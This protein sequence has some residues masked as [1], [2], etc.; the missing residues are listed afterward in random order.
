MKVLVLGAS[1]ATG[2]LVVMQLLLR[3]INVRVVVRESAALPREILDNPL[4]EI[5]KGSITEFT[6]TAMR[7]LLQGCDTVV[8]CL[9][10]NITFKGLFGKP[11]NL[12]SHT[13]EKISEIAMEKGD[14]KIK[15]ILMSTTA[16]ANTHTGEKR[17][18][19]ERIILSLL[20]LFLPPHAD[21]VRSAEYLYKEI[22]KDN[23]NVQ[24][25]AVRPD[26]LV[27][28]EIVNPYQVVE[29]PTRSPLFNA[30]TSS[31]INVAHF[32]AEL[33]TDEELWQQWQSKMPVVYN[34]E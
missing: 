12:V 34:K 16:Y 19:G 30:G 31:R 21:N 7:S 11:R 3:E 25:V 10:H 18:L 22:G 29:S 27:N 5:V 24:W 32:M 28:E 26:T 15:F 14:I 6:D 9:G 8:S 1:G 20:K 2:K 4:V 23:K 13:V 33:I 17:S